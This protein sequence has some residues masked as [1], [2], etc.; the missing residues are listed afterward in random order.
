MSPFLSSFTAAV[1]QVIAI[2]LVRPARRG[3]DTPDPRDMWFWPADKGPG[4]APRGPYHDAPAV[5][6]SFL[7]EFTP[8]LPVPGGPPH[9]LTFV[10]GL[11]D[12]LGVP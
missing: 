3:D 12:L 2:A 9:P 6:R 8:Q 7:G 4:D 5:E 10:N 11:L 1:A